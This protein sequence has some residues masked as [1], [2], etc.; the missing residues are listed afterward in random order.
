VLQAILGFR[1]Q[2]CN[3]RSNSNKCTFLFSTEFFFDVFRDQR[4]GNAL[5]YVTGQC[6]QASYIVSKGNLPNFE[7]APKCIKFNK[8]H[9]DISLPP[10][11][12]KNQRKESILHRF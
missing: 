8:M 2:Y 5:F 3:G 9:E 10:A 1:M 11:K 6:K 7:T 12:L 4:K